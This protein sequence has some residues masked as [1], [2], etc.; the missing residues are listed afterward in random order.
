MAI[1]LIALIGCKYVY[2]MRNW[3]DSRGARIEY[4]WAKFLGKEIIGL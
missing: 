3:E 4:K 1:C 2:F